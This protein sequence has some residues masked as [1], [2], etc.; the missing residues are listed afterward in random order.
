M[1]LQDLTPQLRTR[2]SRVERLVGMF[3]FLAALL[4]GTAFVYYL[5]Q[6]SER[7]G[8]FV[9][10][11]PYYCYTRDAIGLKAGDP[12][13][14]LGREVGRIVLVDTTPSDEWFIT[15]NYNVF[16][17]FEVRQPYYGYI[18]T[19][20]RVRFVTPDFFSPRYLEV[21]RGTNGVATVFDPKRFE[22]AK[23][24]FEK[25]PQDPISLRAVRSGQWQPEDRPEGTNA[26][27]RSGKPPP[28]VFLLTDESPTLAQRA[29]EIVQTAA[30]ALPALTNRLDQV[31]VQAAG[32]ASNANLLLTELQPP[33]TQLRDILARIQSQDGA[34]GRMLLTSNLQGQVESTLAG[35]EGTLTNTTA[36]IRTSETQLQDLTR[37]I[38]VTLDNVALVTSN[39]SAQVNANSLVLGEV[40]SL[41]VNADDMVQGLKRHWLLR[42]AFAGATNPPLESVVA[43]SVGLP[44]AALPRP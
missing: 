17:K 29:E 35:M 26:V 14:L 44:P 21:T 4:M 20:S 23:L 8:W 25:S 15:N 16:V 38:A 40:S 41:V 11:V 39:L 5:W 9:N 6:T 30:L 27:V 2:M 43:P 10:K 28:G 34:I 1:A 13:R 32:A 7:R 18:W 24:Y 31:L 37:R 22:D 3:V 12:V 19:D 36:L 42:S 33:L